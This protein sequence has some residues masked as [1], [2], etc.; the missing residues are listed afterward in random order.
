MVDDP[1]TEQE[2]QLLHIVFGF[3][4]TLTVAHTQEELYSET[5]TKKYDLFP[6]LRINRDITNHF[7]QQQTEGYKTELL[8]ASFGTPARVELLKSALS[9]LQKQGTNIQLHIVTKSVLADVKQ[10]LESHD[11]LKFFH[12]IV[13]KG[14][15]ENQLVVYYNDETEKVQTVNTDAKGYITSLISTGGQVVYIDSERM[16]EEKFS[17]R[18]ESSGGGTEEKDEK[19]LVLNIPPPEDIYREGGGFNWVSEAS[20]SFKALKALRSDKPDKNAEFVEAANN[21]NKKIVPKSEKT[22]GKKNQQGEQ[23]EVGSECVLL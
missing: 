4:C 16:I 19:F 3:D 18:S 20:D 1:K 12:T 8:K 14:D 17:D 9:K 10:G 2:N 7:K 21:L 23:R 6:L 13:A 22:R 11:L 15:D 5:T